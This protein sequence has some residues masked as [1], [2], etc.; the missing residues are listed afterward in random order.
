MPAPSSSPSVLLDAVIE[1]GRP[2]APLDAAESISLLQ[3]LSAVPDPRK[4][5]GRRHSLRSVL[6]LAVGAVLAGAR[7]YAAIAPW[8]AQAEQTLAVCARRRT[9]PR[10]AGYS[11]RSTRPPC[12]RR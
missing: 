11:P 3:A 2:P 12:S 1:A 7:S 8:A 10:S 9:R 4:A 6:L 5:R